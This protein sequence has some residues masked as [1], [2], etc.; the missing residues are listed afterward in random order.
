MAEQGHGGVPPP[1]GPFDPHQL[2]QPTPVNA[3]HHPPAAAYLHTIPEDGLYLSHQP[4]LHGLGGI[5]SP[6]PTQQPPP[7]VQPPPFGGAHPP[8]PAPSYAAPSVLQSPGLASNVV[9]QALL[10]LLNAPSTSET[11]KTNIFSLLC[12]ADFRM[13]VLDNM[14]RLDH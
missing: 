14:L 2:Q 8:A 6:A 10:E 11:F 5:L 7:G 9:Q 12:N 3:G 13:H 4:H 1:A